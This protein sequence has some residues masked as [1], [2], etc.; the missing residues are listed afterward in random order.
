MCRQVS[1]GPR[2]ARCDAYVTIGALGRSRSS[3]SGSSGCFEGEEP[4]VDKIA[5]FLR[6]VAPFDTLEDEEL[7][8]VAAACEVESFP[9]GATIMVQGVEPSAHAW[10]IHGGAVELKD[11]GRLV[12]LLGVGEMFGHRSM[13]TRDPVALT[14]T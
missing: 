4:G 6:T 12:D 13:I 8:T 3:P 2:E 1:L 5:G 9:A 7:E 11:D 14:V 10:V